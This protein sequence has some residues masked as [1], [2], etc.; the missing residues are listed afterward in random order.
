MMSSSRPASSSHPSLP[1]S[2]SARCKPPLARADLSTKIAVL[3]A[4]QYKS[5][6]APSDTKTVLNLLETKQSCAMHVVDL[7]SKR[8]HH[9]FLRSLHAFDAQKV[10]DRL[11]RDR[12]FNASV[13]QVPGHTLDELY[14][15]L[16]QYDQPGAAVRNYA[17]GR[18]GMV[19]QEIA[20]GL[21]ASSS[22]RSLNRRSAVAGEVVSRKTIAIDSLIHKC[23]L[24]EDAGVG[25]KTHKGPIRLKKP[26]QDRIRLRREMHLRVL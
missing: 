5:R 1:R 10:R 22:V 6:F 7:W 23:D 9:S 18:P 12:L 11:E 19:K 17:L 26:E 4:F 24:F 3:D 21:R 8:Q 16:M 13:H 2:R 20:S 14:D 25:S 15:R